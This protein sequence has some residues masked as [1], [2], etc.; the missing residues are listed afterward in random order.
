MR[1]PS[2]HEILPIGN[3]DRNT[4]ATENKEDN[5]EQDQEQFDEDDSLQS[6]ESEQIDSFYSEGTY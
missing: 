1:P 6:V 5:Q 3:E 2:I 4:R